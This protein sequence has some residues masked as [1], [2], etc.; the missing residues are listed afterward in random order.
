M[1]ENDQQVTWTAKLP[2]LAA[3]I[4]LALAGVIVW[5]YGKSKSAT[6]TA[7]VLLTLGAAFIGY[8]MTIKEWC[9][10]NQKSAFSAAFSPSLRGCLRMKGW[11]EF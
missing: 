9:V 10:V 11:A 1:P 7:L 5:A 6:I 4:I 2:T 8:S 3:G